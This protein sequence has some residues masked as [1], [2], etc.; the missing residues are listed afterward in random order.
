MNENEKAEALKRWAAGWPDLD[1][2][3]KLNAI[4]TEDGDRSINVVSND[5]VLSQYIDGTAL[6]EY[7]FALKAMLPWSDG[8]DDVNSDAQGLA[9]SWL[10][11]VADQWPDNLPDWEGAKITALEPLYNTPT[12]SMVYQDDGVAEYMFQAKITYE[13]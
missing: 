8:Y 4:V 13:E 7:T 5:Y 6:R 10:S 2:Y 3:L 12:L 1:G 9:H 11:W